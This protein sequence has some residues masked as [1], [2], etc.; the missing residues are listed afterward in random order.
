MGNDVL[1][2]SWILA[3]PRLEYA[4]AAGVRFL[5]CKH[6]LDAS[7]GDLLLMRDGVL[8]E[9]ELLG[10]TERS[11]DPASHYLKVAFAQY[12]QM[13]MWFGKDIPFIF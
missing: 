7:R 9:L 1:D 12:R 8:A 3:N 11:Y 13:N 10:I 2:Y 5:A 6:G 4:V